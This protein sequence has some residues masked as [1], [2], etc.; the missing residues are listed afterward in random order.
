MIEP[1]YFL[2]S[3]SLDWTFQAHLHA[4]FH[5]AHSFKHIQSK[6]CSWTQVRACSF[7]KKK[8]RKKSWHTLPQWVMWGLIPGWESEISLPEPS[9]KQAGYKGSRSKCPSPS[10]LCVSLASQ[11]SPVLRWRREQHS[12]S[13]GILCQTKANLK[14]FK[15]QMRRWSDA[16]PS[17]SGNTTCYRTAQNP[18]SRFLRSPSPLS[19]SPLPDPAPLVLSLSLSLTLACIFIHCGSSPHRHAYTHTALSTQTYANNRDKQTY[20]EKKK[21][22]KLLSASLEYLSS[23]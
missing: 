2:S 17:S 1:Q 5:F 14:Q 6:Q 9:V 19:F 22:A 21:K 13:R 18:L 8:E 16:P 4:H 10:F 23:M 7:S 11:Q 15:S 20:Q 3:H 12:T